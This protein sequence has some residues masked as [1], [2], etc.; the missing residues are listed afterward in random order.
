MKIELG[1]YGVWQSAFAS[2][3]EMAVEIER[4]GFTALWLGGPPGDLKGIDELLQATES[5]VGGSSIVNVWPGDPAVVAA[6]PR[7][8]TA[9][10]PRRM[11][12]GI[13]AGPPQQ[14]PRYGRTTDAGPHLL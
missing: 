13:R 1:K 7:P 14:T 11:A 9:R 6:A 3:P 5:L 8:G 2:T 4:L 12:L 10:F